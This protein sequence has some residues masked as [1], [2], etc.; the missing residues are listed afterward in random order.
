MNIDNLVI[1]ITRKCNARCDHCLRGDAQNVD[2]DDAVIDA[3]LE[4]VS[5]ITTVTFTGGE[6]SLA[7]PKIKYFL[8]AIKRRDIE[9]NSFYLV[10]NGKE[11]SIEMV[12]ALMELYAYCSDQA[13]ENFSSFCISKDQYHEYDIGDTSDADKLYRA[14]SFYH[15][16]ERS[17][18]IK[19]EALIREGRAIDFGKR[20]ITPDSL[21]F[22]LDDDEHINYIE[23]MV[24]V[25]A[26]GDVI[27]GCDFSFE[28]QERIKIGSVLNNTLEDI[29]INAKEV[30]A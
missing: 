16:D 28:T 27:P 29:Y 22:S 21:E 13:C 25:N 11:K 20:V 3:L 5:Y 26:L 15:P 17:E 19:N 14:L 2:M 12:M 6:P 1:E 8:E 4:G 24:Y 23:G 10:T 30:E 7:V 18:E 9:L